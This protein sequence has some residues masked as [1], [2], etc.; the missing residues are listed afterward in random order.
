MRFAVVGAGAV[1]GYFGAKLAADG[2]DVV[3][4]ARGAQRRAMEENGLRVRSPAGDLHIEAPQVFEDPRE[5]GLCDYVLFC[6][7]LWDTQSAAEAIKPILAH[8]TAVVSLQ[9]GVEAEDMLTAVLGRRFV[10][11][12]VAYIFS[13]IS[14]PGVILHGGEHAKIVVGELDGASTWRQEALLSA[15]IGA[16]VAV[17]ASKDIRAEIWSKFALL[18]PLAGATCVGRCSVGAVREEP[19]LRAKLEA[20]TAEAAAVARARGVKLEDG[21][22][23]RLMER[24][25]HLPGDVKTSMLHDLEAGRPLELEWLNGAVV[26]L[27]RQAGVATPVNAEVVAAL[28][29]FAAG[30]A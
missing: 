20:M 14:E 17:E 22:E 1:G 6:V 15:F 2:N 10:M 16:G 21:L 26:R 18:A 29:P 3:F 28:A 13:R 27:G 5:A 8:D 25:G 23:A 9:N 24:V 30:S 11:G 19:S 4:I 7:K 12:G